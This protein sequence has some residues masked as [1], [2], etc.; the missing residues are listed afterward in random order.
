MNIVITGGAGFLGQRVLAALLQQPGLPDADG[1]EQPVE[2]FIVLD[3]VAG[4]VRPGGPRADDGDPHTVT[5][6]K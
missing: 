1:T 4:G 3:Q 5:S 2:T 6:S